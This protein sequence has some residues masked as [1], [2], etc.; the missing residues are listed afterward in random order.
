[1]YK[2]R[3]HPDNGELGGMMREKKWEIEKR[4]YPPCISH[5]EMEGAVGTTVEVT[6]RRLIHENIYTNKHE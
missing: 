3:K 1:M 4:P 6:R 2:I 5:K